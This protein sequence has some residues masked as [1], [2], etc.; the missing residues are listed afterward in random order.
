MQEGVAAYRKQQY[1]AAIEKF[2]G[3][4][5]A[6]GQYNLGNALARVGRYDEAIAAYSRSQVQADERLRLARIAYEKGGGTLLDVLD[7]HPAA[8]QARKG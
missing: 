4:Q 5:T 2:G 3:N 8:T 1:D 6:D 7:A